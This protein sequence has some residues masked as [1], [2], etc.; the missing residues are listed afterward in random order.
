VAGE[1]GGVAAGEKPV[2][3]IICGWR[4]VAMKAIGAEK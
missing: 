2:L 3:A 1:N 4:G